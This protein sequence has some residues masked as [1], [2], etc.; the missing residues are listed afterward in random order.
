MTQNFRQ[1]ISPVLGWFT[2]SYEFCTHKHEGG[3]AQDT[4]SLQAA[5][6]LQLGGLTLQTC[7]VE[8]DGVAVE[9]AETL[10]FLMSD[11]TAH[12]GH[13]GLWPGNDRLG[14]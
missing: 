4:G 3:A 1:A 14:F 6:R 13:H 5:D 2:V 8:V 11:V 9:W 7:Q 12:L 10:T